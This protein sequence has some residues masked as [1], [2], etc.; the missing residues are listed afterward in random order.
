M[1]TGPRYKVAFRRRREGK[2]DYRLRL[3]LLI[4]RK[5]RLVIRKT[6]RQTRMQIIVPK[7]EGDATLADAT[8]L[9]LRKYG[10]KGSTSNVPAA[11]LT[12]RL[13]AKKASKAGI[14]GAILDI[15]LH[16]STRG[17]RLYAALKGAVDGGLD[18]PHDPEIFP[19]E[20]R[21]RGEHIPEEL[22]VEE[23]LRRLEG[24]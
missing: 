18:V 23:A 13:L 2:T 17:S 15:G 16:P 4:S 1:A 9:E 7:P 14:T 11:Y 5:P 3:K 10:Y 6:S 20:E 19:S 8:S 21:I 24:E 12:G 22:G